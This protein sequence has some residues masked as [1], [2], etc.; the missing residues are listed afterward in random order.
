MII[1][2]LIFLSVVL[3]ILNV[4]LYII[5]CRHSQRFNVGDVIFVMFLGLIPIINL[6]YVL[7]G[8][9]SVSS[10]IGLDK[11]IDNFLKGKKE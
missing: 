9:A 6:V 5:E 1:Y 3:P 4:I 7:W 11:K 2:L 8:I 10:N